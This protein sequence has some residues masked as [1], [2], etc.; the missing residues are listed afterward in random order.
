MAELKERHVAATEQVNALRERLKQGRQSLLDTD[1][2]IFHF[3]F[4]EFCCFVLW[5]FF[6]F[7]E[8]I[9]SF[10]CSYVCFDLL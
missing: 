4:F 7:D 8:K 3:G 6:F 1:G 5:F 10:Y 9:F 2:E